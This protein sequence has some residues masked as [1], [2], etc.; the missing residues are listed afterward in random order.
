MLPPT[1]RT[2]DHFWHSL[3]MR[4]AKNLAGGFEA[5]SPPLINTLTLVAAALVAPF[6]HT[7][8]PR[9]STRSPP[10]G[11]CRQSIQAA[12]AGSQYRQPIQAVNTGSQ[13]KC[14]PRSFGGSTWERTFLAIPTSTRF[15]LLVCTSLIATKKPC[16]F[17]TTCQPYHTALPHSPTVQLYHTALPHRA[18]SSGNKPRHPQGRKKAVCCP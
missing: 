16:T 10:R 8:N 4:A 15:P 12:N 6:D 3:G 1:E 17:Q 5:R 9:M 2:Y 13:Y 14:L 18:N 7:I 11:Q